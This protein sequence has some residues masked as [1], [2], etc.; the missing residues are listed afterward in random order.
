[1]KIGY[2]CINR[3]V[4]CYGEKTFRLKSYS[5]DKLISTV[6]NNLVCLQKILEYNVKNSLLFFRISSDLVPFASHPICTYKWQHHFKNEFQSI[7]RFIQNHNMR[8][9][10]HPDQFIVLNSPYK[11]VVKRSIAEL[12]YHADILELMNLD[13]SAKIQLHVGGVYTDKSTAQKRFLKRY[14][15]LPESIQRRL[16][17]ENDD[18]LYSVKDCL[19]LS[20]QTQMPILLD[21]FHHSLLN[22]GESI[23][24]A[25]TSIQPTWK[26]NDGIPMV[27]Y[28]NQKPNYRAGAHAE[29]IDEGLFTTF[30]K[31]S[32]PY[33]IDIML[34]I[35]DKE[36]SAIKAINIAQHDSRYYRT[37]VT[38]E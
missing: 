34:E 11:G 14:S 6:S 31:K 21:S 26:E 37:E 27:D 7:G 32:R 12:Q 38:Y 23:Q 10:M 8:I 30:L 3:T 2:P 17:I 22:N 1:M 19:F 28:S 36:K 20:S 25:L 15:E 4:V 13:N 24:N 5:V 35:K 18:R 9:S 16:V 29:Y 33:D